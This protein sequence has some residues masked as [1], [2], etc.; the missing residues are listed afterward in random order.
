[1]AQ[2]YG[3]SPIVT[4]GLIFY[5]DAGNT[6]SYT[7]GST[8]AYDLMNSSITGSLVNAMAY[9]TE[10]GGS[11]FCDGTDDYAVFPL[12]DDIYKSGF[13]EATI[14]VWVKYY[15]AGALSLRAIWSYSAYQ[16]GWSLHGRTAAKIDTLFLASSGLKTARDTTAWSD[17]WNLISCTWNGDG[18]G[19]KLYKNGVVGGTVGAGSGTSTATDKNLVLGG[20]TDFTNGDWHGWV[21]SLRIYNK[22]LPQA[23]I[24]QN[25]NSQKARFGL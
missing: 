5:A 9:N 22:A 3:P 15:T 13:S 6:R 25:Y 2:S 16:G 8:D 11:W 17:G 19:L 21:T 24:L 14:E 18:T 20:G 7:S 4:D 1:M 23:E 10:G 12:M